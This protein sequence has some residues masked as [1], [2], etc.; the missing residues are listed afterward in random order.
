MKHYNGMDDVPV[1]DSS[2]GITGFETNALR[3]KT[4]CEEM[5]EGA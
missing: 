4:I 2:F 5:M 1:K 3:I